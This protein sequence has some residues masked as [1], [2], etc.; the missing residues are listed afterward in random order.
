MLSWIVWCVGLT[1]AANVILFALRLIRAT[2]VAWQSDRDHAKVA[3]LPRVHPR[4]AVPR[5]RRDP[6]T[7]RVVQ[8][9][10]ED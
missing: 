7:Q 6:V 3:A 10:P 2:Y 8:S 4:S 5:L 1:L 9:P